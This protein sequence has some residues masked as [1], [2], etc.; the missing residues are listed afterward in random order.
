[1]DD[2]YY[3]RVLGRVQGP[4]TVDRLQS[5]AARGKFARHYHVSTDGSTWAPASDY[6]ELFPAPPI[7]RFAPVPVNSRA[8]VE[9][10]PVQEDELLL[11]PSG[12]EQQCHRDAGLEQHATEP[13]ETEW[14]YTHNDREL[15]PASLSQLQLLAA[16]GELEPDDFV[17]TDGIEQ[18]VEAA[19]VE[20]LFSEPNGNVG[21]ETVSQWA[22]PESASK[23]SAMAVACF[24]LGLLGTTI[25]FFL[26]S[27]LAVVFGHVALKQ[28]RESESPVGGRGMALAGLILGYV[29]IIGGTVTGLIF[30]CFLALQSTM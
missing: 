14:Y 13:S 3:I 25:F 30:V 20:G 16:V 26:G 5:L 24:V 7:P 1:L 11:E 28:I 23:T 17:W 22:T 10:A 18:W 12:N 4:Y 29:I 6:P 9:S 27:I 21:G 15:G 8:K 2:Q 19:R